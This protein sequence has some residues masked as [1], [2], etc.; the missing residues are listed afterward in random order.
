MELVHHTPLGILNHVMV[1]ELEDGLPDRIDYHGVLLE[2]PEHPLERPSQHHFGHQKDS[3]D[4]FDLPSLEN[5]DR[6]SRG[7]G[8]LVDTKPLKL[9][10][11]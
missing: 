10:C 9:L 8:I 11:R 1:Q 7:L 4:S 6:D 2:S 3:D 5:G